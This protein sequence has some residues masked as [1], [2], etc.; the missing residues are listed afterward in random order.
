MVNGLIMNSNKIPV[1]IAL[2]SMVS[3]IN[4]DVEDDYDVTSINWHDTEVTR[5]T[6]EA[7]EQT[8]QQMAADKAAIEYIKLRTDGKYELVDAQNGEKTLV[9]TQDGYPAIEQ[10]LDL[11]Y[12]DIK[13]GN[14]ANG[15]WIST[16]ESVKTK[17][18]K[19]V[20]GSQ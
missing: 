14:L 3:T 8:R 20:G 10:Q 17:F 12:H 4:W 15:S 13:N 9:K 7:I 18:P 2:A 16:I 6:D 5:P 19:P 11:L 1:S